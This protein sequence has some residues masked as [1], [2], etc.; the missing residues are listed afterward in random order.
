[1]ALYETEYSLREGL[2]DE[3]KTATGVYPRTV[4]AGS[5]SGLKHF[6]ETGRKVGSVLPD[7]IDSTGV[8]ITAA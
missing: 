8:E 7:E 2:T 4:I 6:A 5:L 3:E 1:V